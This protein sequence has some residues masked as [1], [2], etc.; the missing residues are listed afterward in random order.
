MTINDCTRILWAM[1]LAA[2]A[3]LLAYFHMKEDDR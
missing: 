1:S 3:L 2:A